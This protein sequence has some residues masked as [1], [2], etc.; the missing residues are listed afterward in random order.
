MDRRREKA[1]RN[2]KS[3]CEMAEIDLFL[4][5]MKPVK[6][7]NYPTPLVI[8]FVKKIKRRL[9]KAVFNLILMRKQIGYPLCMFT[10]FTGF[11]RHFG[12]FLSE[13]DGKVVQIARFLLKSRLFPVSSYEYC[14][15]LCICS[16][17][18]GVF[19]HGLFSAGV[20]PGELMRNLKF[21]GKKGPGTGDG[22]RK[23]GAELCI[24]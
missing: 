24:R 17:S 5:K 10:G 18:K 14:E 3:W 15:Y 11:T 6:P 22:R 1:L 9:K 4:L 2:R 23:M 19:C 13:N 21:T 8:C 16:G 7:M 20:K 12:R